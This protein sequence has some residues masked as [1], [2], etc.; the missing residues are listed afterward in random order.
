MFDGVLPE[1]NCDLDKSDPV[2]RDWIKESRSR[3]A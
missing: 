1:T 2:A 3:A